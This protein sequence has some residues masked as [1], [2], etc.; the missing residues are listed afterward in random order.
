MHVHEEGVVELGEQFLLT[1]DLLYV[2]LS[3]NACLGH[4]LHSVGL[5]AYAVSSLV[6]AAEAS[7]ANGTQIGEAALADQSELCV[8]LRNTSFQERVAL[9]GLHELNY[10]AACYNLPDDD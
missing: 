9:Q 7:F 10:R 3:E 5:V 6:H 2:F 8:N 1:H 4:L